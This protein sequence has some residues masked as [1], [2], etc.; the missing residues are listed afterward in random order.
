MERGFFRQKIQQWPFKRAQPHPLDQREESLRVSPKT[1]YWELLIGSGSKG[2]GK[3]NRDFG[4]HF[5]G[6][7]FRCVAVADGVGESPISWEG[8]EIAVSTFIEEVKK[9]DQEEGRLTVENLQSIWIAAGEAVKK[10]YEEDPERFNDPRILSS[11]FLATTL[12]A[13][14]ELDSSYLVTYLG[15]G[16]IWLV[17]GDFWE[18][19]DTPRKW[20][21]CLTDLVVPHTKYRGEEALSGIIDHRGLRGDPSILEIRKNQRDGE[22]FLLTTDGISSQDKL[23]VM[24]IE[25]SG[26]LL[27]LG[28]ER[29][30]DPRIIELNT[31]IL[32]ILRMLQRYL[33]LLC[34][35]INIPLSRCIH[36]YLQSHKFDDDATLGILISEQ[37]KIGF[38]KGHQKK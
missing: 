2:A 10:R 7:T 11:S 25:P 17:R 24:G 36:A 12:L 6:K 28:K 30:E 19:L 21:W 20:P 1:P 27:P 23:A 16:S 8:A 15:N 37:A 4:S 18:F 31:H 33:D 38:Q 35:G 9:A 3:R 13:V 29:Q 34:R 5:A 22:I 14:V 32:D 26:K